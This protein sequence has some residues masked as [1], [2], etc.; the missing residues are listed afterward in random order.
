M[1]IDLK[2]VGA[3]VAADILGTLKTSASKFVQDNQASVVILGEDVVRSVLAAHLHDAL[4]LIP[5]LPASPTAAQIA[6]REQVLAQRTAVFQIVSEA[7]AKNAQAVAAL[8]ATALG[9]AQ[10]VAS[11][12]LGIAGGAAGKLLLS[13]I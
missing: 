4:P 13:V 10:T 6:A 5:D 8:K 12:V 11:T 3:A 1:E 2:A 9:Y 7:E